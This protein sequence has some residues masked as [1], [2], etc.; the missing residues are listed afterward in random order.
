MIFLLLFRGHIRE[1]NLYCGNYVIFVYKTDLQTRRS[2]D[3]LQVQFLY[4]TEDKKVRES[5]TRTKTI[6]KF[7]YRLRPGP[8]REDG[9][10][11][12][13]GVTTRV[14]FTKVQNQFITECSLKGVRGGPRGHS[15]EESLHP[16]VYK[17][18]VQPRNYKKEIIYTRKIRLLLNS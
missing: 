5:S 16:R 8:R 1:R 3:V 13:R 17:R 11:P 18:E 2:H 10:G 6:S 15:Q 9:P 4:F 14:G 7:Q 12:T